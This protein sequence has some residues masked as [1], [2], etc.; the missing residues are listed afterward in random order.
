[1]EDPVPEPAGLGWTATVTQAGQPD[2][3]HSRW[4]LPVLPVRMAGIPHSWL[5]TGVRDA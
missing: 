2:A 3:N 4:T 5:V 1:M